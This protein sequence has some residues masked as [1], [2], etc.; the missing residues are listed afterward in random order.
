MCIKLEHQRKM[1]IQKTGDSTICY[2]LRV[3]CY[4][5]RVLLYRMYCLSNV[6]QKLEKLENIQ[7]LVPVVRPH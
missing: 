5:L 1:C 3:A 7:D 4:V 2:V 6:W